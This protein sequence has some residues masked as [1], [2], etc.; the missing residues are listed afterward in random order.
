LKKKEYFK[1]TEIMDDY[2]LYPTLLGID[3][4]FEINVVLNF[5]KRQ[6][7]FETKT[8]WLIVPLYTNE[9][10]IYNELIN[11]DAHSSIIENF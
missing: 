3:W 7:S 11:E 6:M 2:D 5:K 1:V 10:Y 4:A 9:V 8:L